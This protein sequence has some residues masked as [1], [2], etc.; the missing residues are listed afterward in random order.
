MKFKN[1]SDIADINN[2]PS[3]VIPLL[4]NV[5][6]KMSI[7]GTKVN[8]SH[9]TDEKTAAIFNEELHD[10]NI[11][12]K[13]SAIEDSASSRLE[14]TLYDRSM[15]RIGEIYKEGDKCII[16]YL[17]GFAHILSKPSSYKIFVKYLL[18]CIGHE[19]IHMLQGVTGGITEL[20]EKYL[21]QPHEI[22][23]FA[24]VAA[25]ELYRKYKGSRILI[26]NHIEN[27][28]MDLKSSPHFTTYVEMF[29]EKKPEV[30]KKFK[31]YMN[32][33]LDIPEIFK[34]LN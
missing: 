22:M 10:D 13:P 16:E 28:I 15:Y 25:S 9:L 17:P 11:V 7:I 27:D 4:D 29:K 23:A 24:Y 32:D 21:M 2:M 19:L 6:E 18:P 1:L 33:Y 14:G 8:D 20:N 31:K 5:S 3:V 30:L 12:F 34:Y 26:R